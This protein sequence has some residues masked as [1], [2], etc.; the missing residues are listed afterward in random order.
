MTSTDPTGVAS[1]EGPALAAPTTPWWRIVLALVLTAAVVVLL[2]REVGGVERSAQAF[3]QARWQYLPIS[4]GLLC[5]VLLLSV[6]K[7][8]VVLESMGYRVSFRDAL[9]A[10]MTS[11]PVAAITPSRAGDFLRASVLAPAVPLM[12]GLGSVLVDRLVD[13]QSLCLLAI[14]GALLT[15]RWGVAGLLLGGLL[16]AWTLV[17]L[18]LWR[19]D[20]MLTR[21]PLERIRAPLSQLLDAFV[22]LTGQP[23]M[24]VQQLSYSMAIW[25]LVLSVLYTLTLVFHCGVSPIEV[26]ALWP[27]ATLFGLIPLTLSGLGTRDAAFIYMLGAYGHEGLNEGALLLAT[28]SYVVVSSWLWAV[29]GLPLTLRWLTRPAAPVSPPQSH[30]ARPSTSE[31]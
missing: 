14:G 6:L 9:Y 21:W 25:C 28:F 4:L 30:A 7:W 11:L 15:A 2:F 18:V 1:S 27:L 3:Q 8:R 12:R 24:L 23:R 20:A 26:L 22:S 17:L 5:V 13:I 31:R 16:L 19:R 29:L 10:F